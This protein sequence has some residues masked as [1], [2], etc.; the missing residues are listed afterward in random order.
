MALTDLL[1][2]K[3]ANGKPHIETVMPPSAL[4]GGEV[5][6][7]GSSLRPPELRRPSVRFGDAEGAVVI[8]SDEF[9]VA[10]VPEGASS[11][12]VTVA[13]N[14]ASSNGHQ[15]NIAEMIAENLH[16]VANPAVDAEGNIFVTFSGPRGQK[17]PVSVFKIDT[18]YNVKPFL[19]EL[20]NP[21]A[22]AFDHAGQMYV[23]SR[24]DGT[25]YRVAPNGTMSSYAEGMGI[26]TGMA[27]DK[28]EK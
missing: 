4:P 5:R 16:P 24:F 11:G 12:P 18:N 13:T 15:V 20:M 23:S 27:F 14:G 25:V 19:T 8:S 6:I 9:L 7:I 2:K 17:V 10:R 1:G 28:D 21:T 26:A 3:N 22:I